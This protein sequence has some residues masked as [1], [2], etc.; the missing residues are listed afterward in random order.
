[1][2]GYA[3]AVTAALALMAFLVVLLRSRRL[4]EKYA[5]TWIIVG[6]VVLVLG[7][8][9]NLILWLTKMAGIQT[10][11]N[12]LFAASLL[13]LLIVCI[14]LSVEITGL[15]EETRTLT[16][17]VALLRLDVER[18]RSDGRTT[19]PSVGPAPPENE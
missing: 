3:F 11:T 17:E 7:A 18:S 19:E 4:R 9:P 5:F 16:E 1:M 6:V 10:P 13:V 15:E 8:F 14:Q 12:L 2:S